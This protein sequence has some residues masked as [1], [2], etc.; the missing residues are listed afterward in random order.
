MPRRLQSKCIWCYNVARIWEVPGLCRLQLQLPRP[1]YKSWRAVCCVATVAAFVD[2]P[3]PGSTCPSLKYHNCF[4][5]RKHKHASHLQ[6]CQRHDSNILTDSC[7]RIASAIDSGDMLSSHLSAVLALA[8]ATEYFVDVVS[9]ASLF[10]CSK[11][12]LNAHVTCTP[13]GLGPFW[14]FA[15]GRLD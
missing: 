12:G 1:R 13:I 5:D 8:I 14:H 15:C 7:S 2:T 3:R 9:A 4:I 11:T 10:D 6:H